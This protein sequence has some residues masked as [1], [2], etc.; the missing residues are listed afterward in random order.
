MPG[1]P[2]V[3]ADVAIP[4]SVS[5]CAISSMSFPRGAA[6]A[7]A[8]FSSALDFGPQALVKSLLDRAQKLPEFRQLL[9]ACIRRFG[10]IDVR[11]EHFHFCLRHDILRPRCA[12]GE[13][14]DYA[15]Q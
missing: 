6:S 2:A 15:W 9:R 14:K 11:K 8:N 4:E 3:G 7:P 12:A 5:R 13:R 10:E 1:F